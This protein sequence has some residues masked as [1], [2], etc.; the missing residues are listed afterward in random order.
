MKNIE[1]TGI[2]TRAGEALQTRIE[3]VRVAL[4]ELWNRP[5][6]EQVEIALDRGANGNEVA[7]LPLRIHGS[8]VMSSL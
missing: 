7:E 5:N 8:L 4:G 2:L 1:H 6:T 3:P